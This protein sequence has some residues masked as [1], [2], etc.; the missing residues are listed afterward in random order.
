MGDASYV[1]DDSLDWLDD[2]AL[3]EPSSKEYYSHDVRASASPSIKHTNQIHTELLD[4][5]PISSPFL[6]TTPSRLH[7]FHESL[8]DISGSHPYLIHILHT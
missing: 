4:L 2:I 5:V 3:L 8:G 1:K 6:P 7:A